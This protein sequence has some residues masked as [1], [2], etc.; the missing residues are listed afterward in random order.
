MNDSNFKINDDFI[1]SSKDGKV[2]FTSVLPDMSEIYVFEG[3][4]GAVL[5]EWFNSRRVIGEK[6]VWEKNLNV[7]IEDNDWNQFMDFVSSKK[8]I[9]KET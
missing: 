9:L 7:S 5:T 4:S 3:V 2:S 1:F 8:I 6:A